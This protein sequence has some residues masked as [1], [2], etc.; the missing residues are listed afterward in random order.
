MPDDLLYRRVQLICTLLYSQL[1]GIIF[2]ISEISQK[3][4]LMIV[5]HQFWNRQAPVLGLSGTSF[6]IVRH[7]FWDLTLIFRVQ[8]GAETV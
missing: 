2:G 1:S 4:C 3:W 8:K 5:R 7:Q 6:G